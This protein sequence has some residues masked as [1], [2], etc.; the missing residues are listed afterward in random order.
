[1]DYDE[2]SAFQKYVEIQA[3]KYWEN[4]PVSLA[5]HCIRLSRF[6]SNA[7]SNLRK[8]SKGLKTMSNADLIEF[9]KDHSFKVTVCYLACFRVSLSF[10]I[11]HN[12]FFFNNQGFSLLAN[13]GRYDFNVAISFIAVIFFDHIIVDH[14]LLVFIR[15]DSISIG[16]IY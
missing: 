9:A 5:S 1:M 3:M 7:Y 15:H 11:K 4:G 6:N 16:L 2:L 13:L 10:I 12:I 8:I 14:A